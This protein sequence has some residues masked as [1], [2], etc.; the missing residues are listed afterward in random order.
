[1]KR[2]L[3]GALDM[4]STDLDI[5][6]KYL[7][8]VTDE[9]EKQKAIEEITAMLNSPETP[10]EVKRL[11]IDNREKLEKILTTSLHFEDI[12]A[13][14]EIEGLLDAEE[15][16]TIEMPSPSQEPAG[17]LEIEKAQDTILF[18]ED[19]DALPIPT[20]EALEVKQ[21]E[22]TEEP[23][24]L[25]LEIADELTAVS[26][27]GGRRED[28][29]GALDEDEEEEESEKRRKRKKRKRRRN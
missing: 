27:D 24:S 19:V 2:A 25:L 14:E 7:P 29:E 16:V 12:M 1:M 26:D 4:D 21:I 8:L 20:E 9:G 6:M 28:D 11:F 17:M 10:S 15:E 13:E 18:P 5:Q 22:L 23:S 3:R